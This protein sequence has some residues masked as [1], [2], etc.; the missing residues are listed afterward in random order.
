MDGNILV[1]F[2]VLFN[3]MFDDASIL[4]TIVCNRVFDDNIKVFT[5][6]R[7]DACDANILGFQ[8]SI[9]ANGDSL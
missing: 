1:Q 3:G 2:S 4:V 7:N 9:C 8:F 6:V 5:I